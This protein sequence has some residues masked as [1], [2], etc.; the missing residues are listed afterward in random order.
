MAHFGNLFGSVP[1]GT[2]T[3]K[4]VWLGGG[5]SKI[6]FIFTPNLGE[7]EPILTHIF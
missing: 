6:V 2:V 5:N 1:F 4:D 7:D 3:L